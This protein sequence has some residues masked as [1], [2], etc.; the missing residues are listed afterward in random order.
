MTREDAVKL[1]T[2]L[3]WKAWGRLRR[4]GHSSYQCF[5][6]GNE[7]IWIGLAFIERSSWAHAVN[8]LHDAQG[9]I[10]SILK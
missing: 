4:Y 6:R 7:Y 10:R 5:R 8:F 3:G 1:A 9:E 2:S